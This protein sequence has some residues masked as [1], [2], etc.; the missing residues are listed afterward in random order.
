MARGNQ[1]R[2]NVTFRDNEKEIELYKWVKEKGEIGGISSFV[3]NVLYEKMKQEKEYKKV[4][5]ETKG[6]T[7]DQGPR[8]RAE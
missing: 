2:F 6:R 1:K 8:K 5:K 4:L 3:K 7:P